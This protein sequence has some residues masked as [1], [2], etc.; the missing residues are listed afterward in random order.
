MNREFLEQLSKLG[1]EGELPLTHTESN[2]PFVL[3]I[4][5]R[6]DLELSPGKMVAQGGHAITGCLYNAYSPDETSWVKDGMRKITLKASYKEL[7]EC[8][9]QSFAS[10]LNVFLVLD[11]GYTELET[12]DVTCLGIFGRK[13]EV[14]KYTDKMELY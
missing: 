4:I 14:D 13:E 5:F 9:Y 8:Y 6:D 1:G 12:P 3:K 11:L 2:N 10:D 7:I